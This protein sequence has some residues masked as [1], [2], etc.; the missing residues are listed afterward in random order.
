MLKTME[1]QQN[2][3][4]LEIEAAVASGKAFLRKGLRFIQKV[5]DLNR[6]PLAPYY[7][8]KVCRGLQQPAVK[9]TDPRN[10]Q[11]NPYW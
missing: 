7:K 6:D 11:K 9:W 5:R 1:A 10:H 2:Q 3:Q 8:F 4:S